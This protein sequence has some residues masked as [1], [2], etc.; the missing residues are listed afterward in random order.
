MIKKI[1]V[2]FFAVLLLSGCSTSKRSYVND[3]KHIVQFQ[4]VVGDKV[5]FA[6][7][8]ANISKAGADTLRNQAKWLRIHKL[9]KITAQGHCDERGTREFNIALGE[10]RAEAIKTYLVKLGVNTNR[11]DTVSYGKERPAVVGH[12]KNA[13]KL[14]R[15]GVTAIR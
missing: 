1:A 11:I 3:N 13:W 6:L 8:S 15:R 4:K 2:A 5:F 12:N 9:F 14:N 10:R 7:N